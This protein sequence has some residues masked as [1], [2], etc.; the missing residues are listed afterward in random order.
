ML[1]KGIANACPE[2]SWP[3]IPTNH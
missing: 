3:T 1:F 2:V